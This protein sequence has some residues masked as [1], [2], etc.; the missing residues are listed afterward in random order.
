M[1]RE[2]FRSILVA[3]IIRGNTLIV[4]S[5]D[6]FIQAGDSVIIVTKKS[7]V[8]SLEDILA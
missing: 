8:T 4:P 3:G 2:F 1:S 7:F 5:G 6:D